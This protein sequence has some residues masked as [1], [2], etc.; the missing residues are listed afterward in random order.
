M[1]R[2]RLP[3]LTSSRSTQDRTLDCPRSFIAFTVIPS[4]FARRLATTVHPHQL[5]RLSACDSGRSSNSA[6]SR[7]PGPCLQ[8]T[9]FGLPLDLRLFRNC[10]RARRPCASRT[11]VIDERPPAMEKAH[12]GRHF[13]ARRSPRACTC[14]KC[15]LDQV[16]DDQPFMNPL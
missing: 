1:D 2:T 7:M 11:S 10:P 6:W 14:K 9:V 8:E 4:A 3:F 16:L 12:E 15:L 5:E 13:R